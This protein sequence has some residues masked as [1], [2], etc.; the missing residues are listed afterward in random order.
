MISV[1]KMEYIFFWDID[2]TTLFL[3]VIRIDRSFFFL[4]SFKKNF[5]NNNQNGI[6]W[7][8]RNNNFVF[9]CVP[10]CM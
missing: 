7:M 9:R 6:I 4:D 8:G 10:R 2:H 5:K 1:Q 3:L